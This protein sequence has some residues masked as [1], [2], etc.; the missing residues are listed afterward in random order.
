MATSTAGRKY[1]CKKHKTIGIRVL[2]P[3]SKDDIFI[4]KLCEDEKNKDRG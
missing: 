2:K 3:N 4:C 1:I